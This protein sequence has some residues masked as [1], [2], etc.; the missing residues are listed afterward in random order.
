MIAT[1]HTHDGHSALQPV[2]F[3]DYPPDFLVELAHKCIDN[4]ADVFFGHGEHVIRG[5]EIYKGK[6]IF[7]GLSD[8]IFQL[9][10]TNV[11][12]QARPSSNADPDLTPAQQANQY[13]DFVMKPDN[14]EGLL[15][16]SHYEGG[17]LT[18]VNLYPIDLRY[19]D[20]ISRKSMPHLASGEFARRGP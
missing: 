13:W 15:A 9:N 10:L 16:T 14:M 7:Y 3:S 20:P 17:L 18:R 19:D 8:F 11:E 4:G 1:I 2:H 6:P 5:V 12:G